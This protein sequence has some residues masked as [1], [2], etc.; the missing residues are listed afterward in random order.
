M[1]TL[2]LIF[3]LAGAGVAAQDDTVEWLGSYRQA[4]QQAK[5]QHKPLFVEFRCE[6]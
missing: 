4:L 5:A 1:K 2:G 3:L 6:A